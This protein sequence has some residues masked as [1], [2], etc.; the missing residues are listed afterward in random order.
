MAIGLSL[1]L[2]AALTTAALVIPDLWWLAW[3]SLVPLFAVIRAFRPMRAARCGLFWGACFY[4]MAVGAGV[5]VPTTSSLGLFAAIPGGYAL[6]AALLTRKIGFNPLL[7]ALGWILVEIAFKPLGFDQGLLARTG[8][9]LVA[10]HWIARVLG[11]V[12]AAALVVAVNAALLALLSRARLTLARS[13]VV[14]AAARCVVR[15]SS[16]MMFFEQLFARRR[17]HPRAPPVHRRSVV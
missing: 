4:G 1:G 2:S 8:Q 11:Y 17:T 7:L 3:V 10:I 6:L 15:L 12:F 13:G 14:G 9:E 5:V 16:Q